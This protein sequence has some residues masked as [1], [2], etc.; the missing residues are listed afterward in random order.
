MGIG[1]MV[2]GPGAG[3]GLLGTWKDST[4]GGGSVG[5]REG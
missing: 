3:A 5:G 4:D 2:S 1:L